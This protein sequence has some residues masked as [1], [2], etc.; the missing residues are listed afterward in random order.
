MDEHVYHG[1]NYHNDMNMVIPEGEG[2]KDDLGKKYTFALFLV[3]LMF[4]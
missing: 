3:F 4:L 2:F 1:I